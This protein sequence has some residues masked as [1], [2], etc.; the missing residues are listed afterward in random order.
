MRHSGCE[1]RARGLGP[2]AWQ[3][4]S[5]LQ[6]IPL[7]HESRVTSHLSAISISSTVAAFLQKPR[8]GTVLATFA[9]SC[10]LDLEGSIVAVVAEELLNGPLNIVIRT[11]HTSSFEPLA[12]GSAV[13]ASP[14]VIRVEGWASISLLDAT[15]WDP[16][17][18]PWSAGDIARITE[19]LGV[20]A[21]RVFAEAPAAGVKQIESALAALRSA[22][23]SRTPA[24][25]RS[26]AERLAGLGSGLTPS[27]DDVLV[28]ALVALAAV[29]D[30]DAGD[31]LRSA[32]ADGTA[33]RTT[34]ISDAYLQA[35]A[36]G[37]A[38]QAWHRLLAALAGKS[39]EEVI[40][41]ARGVM[42]F[43][44]TSGVDMLA[45]FLLAVN[46]LMASTQST[47]STRSTLLPADHGDP[48]DK[49]RN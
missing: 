7:S 30:P 22:L 10:Y 6:P 40:A 9:R 33:N 25:V 12:V 35:A 27:G 8:H 46:A 48:A 21:G 41:A 39:T 44:E 3:T 19:N 18:R 31:S 47:Q 32:I 34:R 13:T 49:S 24:S 20:L 14:E 4:P 38:S 37:E 16:T 23:S 17:I 45:G 42:A 26:A 29:P 15:R 36:R 2:R 43:G 1:L 28:G 5:S 11:D